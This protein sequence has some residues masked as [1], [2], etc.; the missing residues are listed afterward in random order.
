MEV[1][2][3]ATK[4][5]REMHFFVIKLIFFGMQ[6]NLCLDECV[7]EEVKSWESPTWCER[8]DR[9]GGVTFCDEIALKIIVLVTYC[10]CRTLFTVIYDP[11]FKCV[12]S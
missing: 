1:H 2:S 4:S 3:S 6:D 10:T 7:G 8:N 5:A 11:D 12:K 9:P